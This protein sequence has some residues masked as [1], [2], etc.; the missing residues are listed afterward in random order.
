MSKTVK[1]RRIHSPMNM[2][3]TNCSETSVF[4]S[5]LSTSRGDKFV[6]ELF[7]S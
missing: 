5:S 6:I 3:Q 7:F 1:Q 4:K 2:E